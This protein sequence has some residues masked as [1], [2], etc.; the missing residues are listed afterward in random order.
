[1]VLIRGFVDQPGSARGHILTTDRPTTS[2]RSAGDDLDAVDD[3]I[4]V[5]ERWVLTCPV[6]RT[7]HA[8]VIAIAAELKLTGI[9]D[10]ETE[11]SPDETVEVPDEVKEE[12]GEDFLTSP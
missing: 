1:M 2:Q 3:W 6:G 10:L 5:G 12:F 8:G 7:E 4:G 9:D 11:L